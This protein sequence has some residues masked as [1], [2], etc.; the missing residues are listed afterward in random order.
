MS[1]FL[2]KLDN[3]EILTV[4]NSNLNIVTAWEVLGG[5]I[6]G[7]HHTKSSYIRGGVGELGFVIGDEC[8]PKYL[9][10]RTL[11]LILGEERG[12]KF[13][14]QDSY[15]EYF[16]ACL[17]KGLFAIQNPNQLKWIKIDRNYAEVKVLTPAETLYTTS[18]TLQVSYGKN[19]NYIYLDIVKT[20]SIP[21]PDPFLSQ[22]LRKT[23]FSDMRQEWVVNRSTF[24]FCDSFMTSTYEYG[25][26][27]LAGF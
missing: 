14:W 15:E 9:L 10:S 3:G 7:L 17:K 6:I 18:F 16:G 27:F 5:P 4:G 11:I 8:R 25:N 1:G 24:I 23:E 20:Y 26:I 12:L 21:S 2:A 22:P 13:Y 19:I